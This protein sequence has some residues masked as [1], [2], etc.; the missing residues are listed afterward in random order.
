M[1]YIHSISIMYSKVV[2]GW[3][4]LQ[5]CLGGGE[6]IYLPLRTCL[7]GHSYW[8]TCLNGDHILWVGMSY[9]K[10]CLN[11]GCVFM[12]DISYRTCLIRG[13]IL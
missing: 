8:K 9:R 5:N 2:S 1:K 10:I 11:G 4:W 3:L 12:K 13:H 7:T 6:N